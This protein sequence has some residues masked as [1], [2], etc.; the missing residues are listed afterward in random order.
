MLSE[1]SAAGAEFLVVGAY[2]LAAHGYLR[3][4]GDIDI[5][6][7]PTRE[8]AERVFAA[9]RKFGAP[10]FDLRVDDLCSPDIVFQVGVA[11]WRID[12]LTSI[13]GV[14]FEDA[15]KEREVIPVSEVAIPVVSYNHLLQN[16][17][18]TGRA[19]DAPDVAW[20]EQHQPPDE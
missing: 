8:N 14:E 1:L 20:L 2:A 6:V 13:A 18:A 16:K 4:T 3:A 11:P 7:R 9:L 5:W 17:R 19:K 12:I 15:W 10:M